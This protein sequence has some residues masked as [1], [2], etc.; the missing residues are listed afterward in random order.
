MIKR[1]LN[2]KKVK[3]QSIYQ[4]EVY[5]YNSNNDNEKNDSK[6]QKLCLNWTFT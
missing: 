5:K 1:L 4:T 3:A 2:W 6:T